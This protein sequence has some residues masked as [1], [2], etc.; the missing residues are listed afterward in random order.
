MSSSLS[1]SEMSRLGTCR[2]PM[3]EPTETRFDVTSIVRL[4]ASRNEPPVQP[5]RCSTL[6]PY[7]TADAAASDLAALLPPNPNIVACT[8]RE[9]RTGHHNELHRRRWE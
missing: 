4:K 2:R 6:A 9:R 5:V 1:T 7:P 8:H 3:P